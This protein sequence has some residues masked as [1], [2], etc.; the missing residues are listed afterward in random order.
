MVYSMED[1]DF[2]LPQELIA[3]EPLDERSA[4]RMLAVDRSSRTFDDKRFAELPEFLREGDVLVLN[5]TKVFPARL[6]GSTSTGA[7]V[8]VFLVE[9]LGDGVW[10]TLAR[11]AK[12]LAPAKR[13]VFGPGLSAE[14]VER[15]ES[16]T[17]RMR[18]EA[19]GDIDAA[20]DRVGKTPLPPY[21]K[22]DSE[23]L[24][25]DRERYQTVFAK[26]R[27]AIAAPTAGL[28]FTPGVLDAIKG[29]GV[30]IAEVTLH[31]GYGTFEPVRVD[32]ISQHRVQPE[33]YGMDGE[34]AEVLNAAR[35]DGR[36]I[37]AVGTTTTR[38]LEYNIAKFERFAEDSGAADLTILPGYEFRAVDALLTNFHLPKS[39]L[40]FLVSAFAGREL[41]MDAYRHAVGERYRFYSYGDCM[42]IQ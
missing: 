36:R 25:A 11:P 30:T 42:F 32:D 10:T 13:I 8:E 22:R 4:S 15:D 24:D 40:L 23:A 1:F 28:H 34:T 31:V 41:I 14:V 39:S 7:K 37:V 2:E 38:T 20:I 29:R 12:R 17:V 3:S 35:I 5:N 9:D 16:G 27:G 33:R 19:D 21:I 6:F 18:F 26:E